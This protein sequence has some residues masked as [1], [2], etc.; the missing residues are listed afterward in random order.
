MTESGSVPRA[1][2]HRSPVPVYRPSERD[3]EAQFLMRER[4]VTPEVAVQMI[5]V[6]GH[7]SAVA[8]AA[9][10]ILADRSLRSGSLRTLRSWLPSSG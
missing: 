9:R 5:S 6:Q 4:G 3:R 8:D 10:D 1:A 2:V 7:G